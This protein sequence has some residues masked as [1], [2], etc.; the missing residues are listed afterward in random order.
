MKEIRSWCPGL[1]DSHSETT[2]GALS[3]WHPGPTIGTTQTI[4]TEDS[5]CIGVQ[6]WSFGRADWNVMSLG[7]YQSWTTRIRNHPHC[8][9]RA[10]GI[11]SVLSMSRSCRCLGRIPSTTMVCTSPRAM[12][13]AVSWTA[14]SG[15][16]AVSLHHYCYHH[17]LKL[18][19]HPVWK[20]LPI[21][22]W[23]AFQE[24]YETMFG[25]QD[26]LVRHRPPTHMH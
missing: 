10:G 6:Y 12:W 25:P 8:L 13:S 9:E 3:D 11:V 7:G 24:R 21:A 19:Q 20:Q 26:R 4:G 1:L 17:Q 18:P 23:G 14:L 16:H 5:D 22:W 15:T 2:F